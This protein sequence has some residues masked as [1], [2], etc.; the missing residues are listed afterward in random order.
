MNFLVAAVFSV[1][2]LLCLSGLSV[3]NLHVLQY[4]LIAL[5]TSAMT[6]LTV[7]A[8]RCSITVGAD[9]AV[10]RKLLYT[11]RVPIDEISR[12]AVGGE[13]TTLLT[14]LYP[15]FELKNGKKLKMSEVALWKVVSGSERRVEE[16][17]DTLNARLKDGSMRN[18]TGN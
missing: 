18:L 10:L 8:S 3:K 4:L 5:G 16:W 14:V 6:W 12:V 17:V 7:R 1:F 15:V 9:D 13:V 11:R 2:V